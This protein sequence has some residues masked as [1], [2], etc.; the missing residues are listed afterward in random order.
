MPEIFEE[1]IFE[2]EIFSDYTPPTGG[3]SSYYYY[4]TKNLKSSESKDGISV[5][6]AAYLLLLS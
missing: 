1:A 2:E 5:L 4:S 6:V 3:D